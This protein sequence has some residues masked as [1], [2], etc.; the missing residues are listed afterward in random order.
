MHLGRIIGTVVASEKVPGLEGIRLLVVQPVSDTGV[1]RGWPIV[2]ADTTQAGPGDVIHFTT[3]REAALAMPEPFVPVDHAI[4][5][6]VDRV[7]GLPLKV[8]EGWPARPK[9]AAGKEDAAGRKGK[10]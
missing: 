2:A 7:A 6:I 8:A 3:S 1:D 4:I 5:A 9:S 10:S